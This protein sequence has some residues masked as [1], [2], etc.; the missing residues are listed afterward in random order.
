MFSALAARFT[1]ASL[2]FGECG[3]GGQIPSDNATRAALIQRFYGY[4]V[5]SVPRYIGG[6]FYWHL[7]QTMVPNGTPDWTVLQSLMSGG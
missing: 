3:W 2:G 6:G 1:S 7:R 4:R 5:P